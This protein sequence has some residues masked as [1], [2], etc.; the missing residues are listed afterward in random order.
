MAGGD[1]KCN[2]YTTYSVWLRK[3]VYV[4]DNADNFSFLYTK[5]SLLFPIPAA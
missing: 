5:G 1:D 4:C 3:G 2:H